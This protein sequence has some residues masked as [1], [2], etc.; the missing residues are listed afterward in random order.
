VDTNDGKKPVVQI[1][2]IYNPYED[3]KLVQSEAEESVIL[4]TREPFN[5]V[6]KHQDIVVGHQR[7]RTL[8]DYPRNARP[9]VRLYALLTLAIL[10]GS[11]IWNLL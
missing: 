8:S 9:W 4:N 2:E 5:D 3:P 7:N 11:L 1:G 10:L 6:V